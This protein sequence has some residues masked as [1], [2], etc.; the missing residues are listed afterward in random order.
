MTAP[1]SSRKEERKPVLI[2]I[3][4][5][6]PSH[7]VVLVEHR[8]DHG[9]THG[10][11]GQDRAEEYAAPIPDGDQPRVDSEGSSEAVNGRARPVPTG[12]SGWAA[13]LARS[14]LSARASTHARPLP[15]YPTPPTRGGRAEAC[16]SPWPEPRRGRSA[17]GRD[18]PRRRSAVVNQSGADQRRRKCRACPSSSLS[19]DCAAPGAMTT[20]LICRSPVLGSSLSMPSSRN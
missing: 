15:G 13:S 1:L 19:A 7:S 17:R 10:A 5:A 6:L 8:R 20:G 3:E 14:S 12:M 18:E 11:D 4:P 9:E 2:G 16:G